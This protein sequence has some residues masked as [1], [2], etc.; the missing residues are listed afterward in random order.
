MKTYESLFELDKYRL[1]VQISWNLMKFASFVAGCH[2][3]RISS[4]P[5][6]M[7]QSHQMDSYS[8]TSNG[9]EST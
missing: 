5:I 9:V 4:K 2:G 3:N 8:T 1:Y 6:G 7:I